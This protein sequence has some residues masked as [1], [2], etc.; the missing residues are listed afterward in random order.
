[1]NTLKT[2]LRILL[3]DDD[4]S[5]TELLAM[6]LESFG[7]LVETAPSGNKALQLLRL[8]PVDLVLTDLRMN[9]MNGFELNQQIQS[10]FPGL[11]VVMM[12]AHGSIPEA[13]EAMQQGFVSFITK[14]IDSVQLAD[15][16]REALG[17]RQHSS[18]EQ[19]AAFHGLIY[20]CQPMQ[21]LVQQIKALATSNANILIQ[22]ESGTGKEVTAQAIH[23]ASHRASGPFVAINCGAVPSHLL[24]SELFGHKK[25][26]FTGAIAD[27]KGIVQTADSGTLF[28][29]EIGDMPLEL[30]VKLLRV[31]QERRVRPV[32]SDTE[33]DVDVRII[34]ASHKDIQ[35][36][37]SDKTFR[38][39]LYYRLNVVTLTLPSLS[40]RIEDIPLLANHFL[41]KLS[42]QT[43]QLSP[44]AI[45]QL[46]TYHWPGNIR[47][48][49]NVIEYCAALAPSKIIG[50]DLIKQAIPD[51]EKSQANFQGL[52][53]AKKA[54]EKDYIQKALT[55][56]QGNV[57]EAAKLA[58]RNRTDFY[59]LLKKHEIQC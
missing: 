49:H 50:E 38:K 22:G 29:D 57:S 17:N 1:M 10:Q 52:N 55:L 14:P 33:I 47:Q 9:H 2:S 24:E 42:N 31:L 27:K 20:Q 56:C 5:L 30:Q 44:G 7:Y 35:S 54:F 6:R 32:G 21:H 51:D 26:A 13:V 43:K 40:Q 53:E 41:A 23:R 15:V 46:L 8:K 3:V 16:L 11:P 19:S 28:L 4:P 34:S 12:T 45:T 39:D 37:I 59:K 48:L 18:A 36:A 58:Q 25:G